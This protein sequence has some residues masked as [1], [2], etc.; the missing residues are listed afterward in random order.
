MVHEHRFDLV[1][2]PDGQGLL[3]GNFDGYVRQC[4]CGE[5]SPDYAKWKAAKEAKEQKRALRKTQRMQEKALDLTPRSDGRLRRVLRIVDDGPLRI[6]SRLSFRAYP[7]FGVPLTVR[8]VEVVEQIAL[9]YS[10]S[11]V[12]AMLGLSYQTIKNH[13]QSI[14][15][16]TGAPNITR[17]CVLYARGMAMNAR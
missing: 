16:K 3:Y 17:V 15:S 13:V 2:G 1:L 12:A 5:F 9:G 11:E 4:K 10:Q 8:E 7:V 14:L 6:E